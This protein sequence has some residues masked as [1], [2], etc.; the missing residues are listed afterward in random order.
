MFAPAN[1]KARELAALPDFG[2]VSVVLLQYP[3]YVPTR[4]ELRRY[5]E[6]RENIAPVVGFLDHLCHPVSLL[7]FLLGMPQTLYYER[8]TAGGGLAT[9]GFASGAVA[10]LALTWKCGHTGGFERTTI[11][12]DAGRH[13][14]VDNNIRVACLQTPPPV[15]GTGYGSNPTFFTGGLADAA[16]WWEPEFSLGQLYNKGLFVLGY[17]NEVNE[18]ARAIL[19]G[20]APAKGTL[21]HAAQVTRIFEAF[22]EGPGRPIRLVS[23]A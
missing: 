9:F 17:Y 7:V 5:L 19:E 3:Q 2:R 21:A 6:S 8:S 12:S 15:P 14:V 16:A 22:A 23:E 18:F 1:E 20:R 11:V 10:S 13:I 4:D